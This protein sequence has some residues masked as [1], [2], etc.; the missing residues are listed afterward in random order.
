[1][2]KKSE[3]KFADLFFN[4]IETFSKTST[5]I[6]QVYSH[7]FSILGKKELNRVL[8][9]YYSMYKGEDDYFKD[10][11]ENWFYY[12]HK[13]IR[14]GDLFDNCYKEGKKV[15]LTPE[16]N[17]ELISLRAKVRSEGY[18]KHNDGKEKFGNFTDEYSRFLH[19]TL[20][21]E[22]ENMP[23][24]ICG[25]LDMILWNTIHIDTDCI[26]EKMIVAT[27]CDFEKEVK[28]NQI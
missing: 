19:L 22:E 28:L 20:N 8:E 13:G 3:F 5:D 27:F 11:K 12:F 1:M 6:V 10:G 9:R 16:E 14:Q 2:E 18:I 7:L 23:D 4:T 15:I 25:H 17:D 26:L 24:S 21:K